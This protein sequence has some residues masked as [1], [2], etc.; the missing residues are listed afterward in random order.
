MSAGNNF[1][2]KTF[3]GQNSA[4][5]TAADGTQVKRTKR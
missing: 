1:K 4:A 2:R 5:T 3:A